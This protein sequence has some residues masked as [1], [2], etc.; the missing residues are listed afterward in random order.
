MVP[1]RAL[2]QCLF[3]FC[4][5]VQ[6][7]SAAGPPVL[8]VGSTSNAFTGYYS[9]ILK[10]EG[11]NAFD[12]SDISSVSA[13]T[14]AN[15]RLVLLGQTSLTS[16]QVTMLTNWVTG[17]GK[18]I[19]MKPDK[20]LAGLLGLVDAS[21][22]LPRGYLLVNTAAAPGM[23][24][25]NQT[26]QFHGTVDLYNVNGA[27]SIATVYSTATTA[28][29]YPAV[30]LRAVGTNGGEAAAFT[31]DLARS[32]IYLATGK[33]RVVGTGARWSSPIRSNDLYFGNASFDPQADW[34]DPNRVGIPQAD[35]QQRL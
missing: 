22:T 27:T 15:Y 29:S 6:L 10:A 21:S 16:A 19:A 20:Q 26:I 31:Y 3:T 17:G 34:I 13:S 24:I 28:T 25:V 18:L 1:A 11:L 33:P 32:T 2:F 30:S 7:S 12:Y 35:E 23:G 9:E 8:V 14:L 5:A 4:L